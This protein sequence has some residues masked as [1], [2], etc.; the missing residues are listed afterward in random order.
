MDSVL[1]GIDR[2]LARVGKRVTHWDSHGETLTVEASST[3][4]AASCPTC[5]RWSNRL[6]G[7]YVRQLEERPV[8]DQR[9]TLAVQMHRFKCPSDT[10][11]RRTFAEC[12]GSLAGRYQR[13]TRSQASA[14]RALGQALGG[15]P[16][17]RLASA[18]GLR[19]SADTVLRQLRLPVTGKRRPRPRVVGIDDW[20]ITRGHNYGTIIV[21]LERR[22]PIE[23]LGGRGT[24]DLLDGSAPIRRSRSYPGTAPVP[25]QKRWR[26]RYR[27][28]YR[29]PIAGTC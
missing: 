10:C 5:H 11:P 15:E 6:H 18:L 17:A 16:A 20:A 1:V 4:R 23:V 27:A 2:V 8:L 12:I 25:T 22:E 24:E 19:T 3:V 7:S 14:L 13:R 26:R 29:Y 28:P 9:L 21:D